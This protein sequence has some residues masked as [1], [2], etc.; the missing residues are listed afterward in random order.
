MQNHIPYNRI[1]DFVNDFFQCRISEGTVYNI[2]NRAFNSLETTE[3]FIK[4][5]LLESP[6]IHADETGYY[7]EKSRKWLFTYS[8]DKYTYYDFHSKRGKEAMDYIGFMPEYRG[9]VTHDCWQSYNKYKNCQHSLC[10]AHLL[11]ELKGISEN[12]AFKFPKSIKELLLEMKKIVETTKNISKEV[13]NTLISRYHKEI[14]L[15]LEEEEKANPNID[16]SGKR[17][18]KPQSPA[19]NLLNRLNKIPEVLGFFIK[20]GLIPFDNNL[21]ERDVR[22]VK[23]KQ[24]VSGLHRSDQGAKQFCRIR[25]YISTI[26]K[27]GMSIWEGLQSIFLGNPILP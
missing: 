6:Q 14:Q 7:V 9:I 13:K 3:R 22:M 1:T 21:A 17:G 24:K 20:P 25:G 8:N 10:N 4:S 15:G 27:N 16:T 26:N 23:V 19:K 11:R 2:L 18:K 12:T 5:K